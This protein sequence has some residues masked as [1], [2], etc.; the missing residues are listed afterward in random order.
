MFRNS[1]KILAHS[2]SRQHS[3]RP[4]IESE[5]KKNIKLK[6]NKLLEV[7]SGHYTENSKNSKQ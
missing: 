4:D 3:K 6:K 2:I 5:S 1:P 7:K